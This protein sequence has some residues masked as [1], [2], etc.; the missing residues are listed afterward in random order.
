MDKGTIWDI[1]AKYFEDI[2][3]GEAELRF[4]VHQGKPVE[5]EEIKTATRKF[6]ISA[7]SSE[8]NGVNSK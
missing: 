8:Q 4:K 5:F 7:L 6:R 1:L 3:Y 2:K